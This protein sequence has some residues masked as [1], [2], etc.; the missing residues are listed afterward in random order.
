MAALLGLAGS[1]VG[2]DG[3]SIAILDPA[4]QLRQFSAC[5]TTPANLLPTVA[6]SLLAGWVR[7]GGEMWDRCTA[8][9]L[10]RGLSCR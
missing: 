1:L 4:P 8:G 7:L 10:G 5:F 3:M 6:V 2:C 9:V